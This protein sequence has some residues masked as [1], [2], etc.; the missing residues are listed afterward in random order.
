LYPLRKL[1]VRLNYGICCRD[2]SDIIAIKVRVGR[3][4]DL[5][6][7]RPETSLQYTQTRYEAHP[8]S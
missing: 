3:S 5:L 2:A 8:V 4:M 1:R 7:E 6:L